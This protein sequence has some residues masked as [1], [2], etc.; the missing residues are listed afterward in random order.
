MLPDRS[1]RD[2][3]SAILSG[4]GSRRVRESCRIGFPSVLAT[5][6]GPH[7]FF[8]TFELASLMAIDREAGIPVNAI[9]ASRA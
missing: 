9:P 3:E 6:Q 2:S 8:I 7:V 5:H 4:A 1:R